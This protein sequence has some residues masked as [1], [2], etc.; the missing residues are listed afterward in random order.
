[1]QAW[2]K[3]LIVPLTFAVLSLI[4]NFI[5]HDHKHHQVNE[6]EF[7]SLCLQESTFVEPRRPKYW[8]HHPN[9]PD[10][11][12]FF[13]MVDL[14][15]GHLGFEQTRVN[16][17]YV[18]NDWDI[19]WCYQF[20][21]LQYL[22]FNWSSLKFYQKINHFPGNH[23]ITSKSL[24]GT[25]TDSK[26]IPRAFKDPQMLKKYAENHPEKRFVMKNKSNRGVHLKKVSEMNFTDSTD[27]NGYFA[28]EFIED[29]LLFNGHKFDFAVYVAITSIQ[30]L[31]A[32]Y[33]TKNMLMR[34]C[35]KKYDLSDPTDTDRYVVSDSKIP[36]WEFNGTKKYF[37]FGYNTKDAFEGFFRGINVDVKDVWRKVE[38]AIREILMLKEKNMIHWVSCG[39]KNI[40]LESKC[41][42]K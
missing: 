35:A 8:F 40:T 14:V 39:W 21:V 32:Y 1:M 23:H 28:Q 9:G 17:T 38:N 10:F 30:P 15:L 18:H 3:V 29:P 11:H 20:H 16:L 12:F 42:L 5:E 34:F 4:G 41:L 2:E 33:Y 13:E 22:P 25:E 36:V 27:I 24:L 37:E 31:R 7:N 26:Y 6:T 19:L